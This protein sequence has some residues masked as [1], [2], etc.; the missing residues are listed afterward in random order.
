MRT[1]AAETR[2]PIEQA[3][4]AQ[5]RAISLAKRTETYKAIRRLAKTERVRLTEERRLAEKADCRGSLLDVS[6]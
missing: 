3:Q 2:L 4:G 1:D 6:A 5:A